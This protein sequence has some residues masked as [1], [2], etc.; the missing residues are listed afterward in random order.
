MKGKGIRMKNKKSNK[1]QKEMKEKNKKALVSKKDTKLKFKHKHP[2]LA[3]ALKIILG[4]IIVV[5]VVGAGI[6]G[7]LIYGLWG[8]DLKI[9][10]SA[11][12]M[13][14]NS[15]IY[16][17]EGNVLAELN[18]NESRKTIKLEEMS[19]YLPKAFIAIED[20]RF[21]Q[22]HGVDF[23]RTTAAVLSFVTHF[24]KST[25]GG[26]S[27]ITQQ[28]VKNVTKDKEASGVDGV[29]RK[30]KE[31]AKA[32]Q[33]ENE[34]SKEQILELY[35]NLIL[36]GKTNYGV[37]AGAE[38][39]FNT[40]AKDLSIAQCAF[41]AGINNSPNAYNPYSTTDNTAK[42]TKRTKT[43]LGQM[44]KC[45][46]INE[47]EYNT[48]VA[49]VE[50]GF[51]FENGVKGNVYSSH[52]D[53][54]IDQLIEQIMAEKNVS[55]TAAETYLKTSGLKIYS[56]EVPSIQNTMEEEMSDPSYVLNAK[57]EKKNVIYDENGDP[58]QAQAAAVII[59][60][61]T[62]YVVGAAGQLG[63]KTTSRGLN[64]ITRP[65]QTGS[66]IKPL[67]D[68]L[69]GIEEGIIT[70]ATIYVDEKTTFG[71]DYTPKNYNGFKGNQTIR[72]ALRTSQNIPFLKVMTELTP[73]KGIEYLRKLGVSTLDD[74]LDNNIASVAIGGFTYGISPLEMAAAYAAIANDGV[75]IK[76]TF[77]TKVEDS[78]GK[79]VMQ[80]TQESERVCSVE[81][82][83]IIKNL[84]KG[85]VSDSGGTATYC[86]I[87]GMD[88]AA[89]TGTTNKDK[90]RWL[91]GFTNYYAAAVIYAFDEPRTITLSN[92]Y[93][94]GK[95]F[96]NV[97]KSIHKDLESSKFSVP[98]GIVTTKVCKVSGMLAS[99]KCTNTYSEIFV[100][101]KLPDT[102]DAHQGSYVIC[103]DSNLLANEY[104]P[105]SSRE[106][107]E[108]GYV[109]E[110][111]RLGLWNTP[112]AKQTTT[113]P[114]EYCTVHKKP[115]VTNK[116]D[117]KKDDKKDNN[118]DNNSNNSNNN[119]S[120]D[121][122]NN[123]N[124]NSDKN[125]NNNSNNNNSNNT[126]N[127]DNNENKDNKDNN[128]NN[129]NNNNSNTN[130]ENSTNDNKTTN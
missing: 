1:K 122:N 79:V 59:D 14:E 52:T 8:D 18:G 62:G 66:S 130:K 119:N 22:H 102:C 25:V 125:N 127:K 112:S 100:K 48:A 36:M 28:L 110:K 33:I 107:K 88:L 73:K 126:N 65:R 41:L 68:V 114:T 82:A 44:K 39:Y 81:T 89:K 94:A 26:G 113:A 12:T 105:E 93:T 56:T 27:T 87:N 32:Y 80:P 111:E 116:D 54:L 50:A 43:V 69:P 46:Y 51:K 57:D 75:Y 108:T 49:E 31:W 103:K 58:V 64:R 106:T 120:S 30:I 99:D 104:C 20:E 23:K 9:D 34:L 128:S 84:M 121:N 6:V 55:K 129:S 53:A 98:D 7:G 17:S 38:Y 91:C 40:T 72:E 29:V 95:I 77:Y 10:I 85:V 83:Y 86:K 71:K 63:E 3:I 4:L 109:V 74:D 11:L 61:K 15:I 21:Y 45:G 13:T 117:E 124:N 101:G 24:G 47:E 60:P 37:E 70:P 16:D 67:S 76:P 2:K 90:E 123:Q 35:L 19:P 92:R 118:K 78:E 115:E 42:I 97:M 5:C 96:A